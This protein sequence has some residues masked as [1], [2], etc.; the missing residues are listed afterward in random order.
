[1]EENELWKVLF[2]R[3]LLQQQA[4]NPA[5]VV[6]TSPPWLKLPRKEHYL[7]IRLP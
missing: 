4:L 5:S 1:M 2:Q 7:P 3:L 6:E